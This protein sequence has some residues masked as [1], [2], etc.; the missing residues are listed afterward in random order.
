MLKATSKHPCRKAVQRAAKLREML[1]NLPPS[2]RGDHAK[3]DARR[4]VQS[5][6]VFKVKPFTRVAK[7]TVDELQRD[8]VNP[9][10]L[11]EEATCV[12]QAGLEAALARMYGDAKRCMKHAN[13]RTLYPSDMRLAAQIRHDD[14]LF[15]NW[16]P[17]GP[18][19]PADARR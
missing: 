19:D 2:T 7:E 1:A 10:R 17:A 5:S 12:L 14:G 3:R 9:V 11:T 8:S 13:R 6:F 18:A 16:R 4:W 15:M